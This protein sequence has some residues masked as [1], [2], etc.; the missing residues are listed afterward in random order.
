[1]NYAA[2]ASAKSFVHINTAYMSVLSAAVGFSSVAFGAIS[3]SYGR[4]ASFCV[5]ASLLGLA[6][7]LIASIL[8][9]DPT[10]RETETV[11]GES[12]C[13]PNSKGTTAL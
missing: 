9:A 6:L 1:M 5:A 13:P 12:S 10:P 4:K 8:P 7:L 11:L 2:T 3:D